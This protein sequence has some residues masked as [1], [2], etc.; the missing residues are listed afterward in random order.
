MN[1]VN[2]I[3]EL[4][5][6]TPSDLEKIRK[7][8][9]SRKFEKEELAELAVAF[10]DNCFCE[11]HDA[12]DPKIDSVTIEN[13]HSHCVVDAIRL[14]LEFGLDPNIIVNDDN[15]LWNAMW[16][17]APNVAASVMRL[18]LENGGNPNHLIPAEDE[19]IF[20][21]IADKVSYDE[22]THEYFHTVQCWL[23]LMAYGACWRDGNIPITMLGEKTV[24]IFKNFELYDYDIEPLP[25]EP[26]KYGCWI[27]H[28]YNINT[29]EEVAVYK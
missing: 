25:Q 12:L 22:Y 17:D 11:Y 15:V 28:I 4:F 5:E 27:M 13:M 6:Q 21:Y 9:G 8:L 1:L 2:Q 14:L 10:T 18:L 7:L 20:E 3:K 26:G 29:K 16:I 23:L 24:D 19:T